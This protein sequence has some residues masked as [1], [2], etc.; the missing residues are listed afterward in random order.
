[1]AGLKEGMGMAAVEMEKPF[2]E[3][4][5]TK[6]FVTLFNK[7]PDGIVCPHFSILAHGSSCGY[8][9][10]YCFLGLTYFRQKYQRP[11]VYVNTKKLLRDVEKFLE[12][13]I[14]SVLNAGELCD[15]LAYDGYTGL[16]MSLVPLFA[17]Q[18]KHKLLFLTKSA[19]VDNLLDLNHTGQTIVSFSVN[20]FKVAELFE[21]GAPHPRERI[22]AAALVKEAGYEL[23]LRVDPIIPINDHW[24]LHYRDLVDY[25]RDA[26]AEP[27]RYTLGT[28][29]FFP[30]LRHINKDRVN[31][32]ALFGLGCEKTSAD[33]RIRYNVEYR[34]RIY[35]MLSNYISSDKVALCKEEESVWDA[36][37]LDRGNVKCNCSL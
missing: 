17:Q 29:R 9:C 16:S 22:A 11:V 14:P 1:M 10:T 6:S 7:T 20:A 35:R 24:Y 30:A 21:A 12:T 3:K 34:T 5:R 13:D 32:D 31:A 8:G 2:D 25:I 18:K 26:G 33:G 4:R 27:L 19:E 36:V 37:G 15:G 28:L 23:R